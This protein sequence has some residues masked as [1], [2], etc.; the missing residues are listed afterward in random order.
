MMTAPPWE[1]VGIGFLAIGL[2][3]VLLVVALCLL[4]KVILRVVKWIGQ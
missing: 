4:G 1:A 2:G 3:L